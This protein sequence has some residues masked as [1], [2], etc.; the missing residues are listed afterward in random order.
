MSVSSSGTQAAGDSEI[1][2]ISADG[3]V[4]VF[5]SEASNLVCAELARCGTTACKNVYARDLKTHT[6]ELV[7][8]S[9]NG[10]PANKRS[11]GRSVS[12]NGRFVAFGSYASNL[13]AGDNNKKRDVYVRDRAKQTTTLLSAVCR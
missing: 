10:L 1:A 7:S 11:F 4:V 6:T 3:H 2:A 5:S 8:V 12:A 9:S 13:V